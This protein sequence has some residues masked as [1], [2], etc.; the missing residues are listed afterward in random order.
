MKKT[1]ITLLL[2]VTL[3][4]IAANVIK[5]AKDNIKKGTKLEETEK[6]LLAELAKSETKHD[7]K[8]ECLRLALECNVK[9]NDAENMKLYLHQKSDT[10]KFFNTILTI[11]KRVEQIDSLEQLPN[12]KGKIK[13]KNR[14]KGRDLM[15]HYRSNLFKGGQY[16]YRKQ[17]YPTAFD[18][19]DEYISSTAHPI[20][21]KDKLQETD[22]LLPRAAY[23]AVTSAN[24]FNN[25]DGIIRYAKLAIDANLKN[26]L[27]QELLCEAWLAKNDTTKHVESL[28]EG[29]N[30][31]P[32]HQYF[33]THLVDYYVAT[34]QLDYGL[35]VVDS[36]IAQNNRNPLYWYAKSLIL[37]KQNKDREVINIC[38]SCL[39]CDSNYVDAYYNKGIASLNLA[40]IYTEQA[41]T[42]LNDPKCKRDQEIIRSLYNLAKLPMEKV[43][44]MQPDQVSRWAAPLYRIYLHLN[45]GEEFDEMD[46]LL[47]QQQ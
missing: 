4:A 23:L 44:E 22:T 3:P 6:N 1:I 10:A 34:K 13:I 26:H 11:F 37:L 43:R 15:L 17:M 29:I 41:C 14:K 2:I 20:L 7:D 39:A 32:S 36:M 16:N 31:Y 12:E 30:K 21:E 18:Y 40:V 9:M 8:I 47:N 38:D 25:Y 5:Q 35:S 46:R 33:F 27:I 42:D 45:M 24:N 28:W 19:L